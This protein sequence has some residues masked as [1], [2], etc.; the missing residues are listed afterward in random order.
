MEQKQRLLRRIKLT[1]KL[2][3]HLFDLS[4]Q[5][6]DE[7]IEIGITWEEMAVVDKALAAKIAVKAGEFTSFTEAYGEARNIFNKYNV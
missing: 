2:R 3:D 4:R 7:A 6:F 1:Q 5:N